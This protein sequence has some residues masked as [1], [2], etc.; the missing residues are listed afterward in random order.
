MSMLSADQTA[1][2]NHFA[3]RVDDKFATVAHDDGPET[4][5]PIL[6]G[7]LAAMECEVADIFP[8][9]DHDIVVG[10]LVWTR[11]D[12]GARD[13]TDAALHTALLRL[14]ERA[15]GIAFVVAADPATVSAAFGCSPTARER[16]PHLVRKRA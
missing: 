14:N 2:S 4:G 11:V 9:G 12:P 6:E 10:K 8:G 15:W 13:R 3:S 1:L 16:R 5:C 7:A